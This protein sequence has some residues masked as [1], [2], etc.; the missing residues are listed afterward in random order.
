MATAVIAPASDMA[1]Y[2]FR[3]RPA[4]EKKVDGIKKTQEGLRGVMADAQFSPIG[5]AE[6][7]PISEERVQEL[8]EAAKTG[9]MDEQVPPVVERKKFPGGGSM[10]T[11]YFSSGES[12]EAT[13]AALEDTV[14]R[15]GDVPLNESGVQE[16]ME[17]YTEELA[18]ERGVA[19]VDAEQEIAAGL[20]DAREAV[21]DAAKWHPISKEA[22]MVGGSGFGMTDDLSRTAEYGNGTLAIDFPPSTVAEAAA[23]LPGSPSIDQLQKAGGITLPPE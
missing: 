15:T 10:T 17:T 9:A 23:N 4:I 3:A 20:S 7:Y 11:H 21:G 2:E 8:R 13:V 6:S 14:E 12:R 1:D 5:A 22:G 16:I 18:E 19:A